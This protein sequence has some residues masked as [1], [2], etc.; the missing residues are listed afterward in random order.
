MKNCE[1]CNKEN[2]GSYGSGRFCSSKCSRSFSTKAKR[3]E[4]NEKVSK[5]LTG[6][7]NDDP[8]LICNNCQKEFRV[9]WKR[10]DQNTCSTKCSTELKWKNEEYRKKVSMKT[11]ER[12]SSTEERKRLRDIG[13]KGGFGKKGITKNGNRY[14]SILEK[15]CFELLEELE[16]KFTPHKPIPNSA[17]ISDVYIHKLDLWIEIDGINREKRKSW[18]GKDYEYW[19]EKIEIYKR[20]NLNFTVVTSFDLFKEK[21]SPLA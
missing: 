17:K 7:G 9:K 6:S 10:R 16:I 2:E 12:C 14:E 1:N 4:I 19:K 3:K 21:I 15:K 20:E 18:L 5:T 11:K 8:V 13:R